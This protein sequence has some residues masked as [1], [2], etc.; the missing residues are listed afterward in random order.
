M[1]M[2][3]QAFNCEGATGKTG[4]KFTAAAKGG[5]L[6]MGLAHYEK[7]G[8]TDGMYARPDAETNQ[9]PAKGSDRI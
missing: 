9:M 1:K 3:K 4:P 5:T 6:G 8:N 2:T 7:T